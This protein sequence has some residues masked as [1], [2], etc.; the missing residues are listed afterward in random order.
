MIS[1]ANAGDINGITLTKEDV[2]LIIQAKKNAL[3]QTGKFEFGKSPYEMLLRAFAD[4]PYINNFTA[5]KNI[6]IES[7]FSA[8]QSRKWGFY[9]LFRK[10]LDFF[11]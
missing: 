3:A 5:N 8:N 9:P 6:K 4:S 1:L 2:T 7:P 11:R 10:F